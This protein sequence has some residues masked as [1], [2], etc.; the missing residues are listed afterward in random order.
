MEKEEE[1]GQRALMLDLIQQLLHSIFKTLKNKKGCGIMML[2][3]RIVV[4]CCEWSHLPCC[5]HCRFYQGSFLWFI[6]R[7]LMVFLAH[8]CTVGGAVTCWESHCW[9]IASCFIS[10]CQCLH[11]HRKH[12]NC[13][14]SVIK[15]LEIGSKIGQFQS[16]PEIQIKIMHR[17]NGSIIR[18]GELLKPCSWSL[19][20]FI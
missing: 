11:L 13:I 5:H 8:A 2:V 14:L 4:S 12:S 6:S 7:T 19:L 15:P 3:W 9:V 10:I 20:F 18:I 16:C 1:N 17:D